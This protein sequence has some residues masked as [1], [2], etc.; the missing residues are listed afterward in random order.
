MVSARSRARSS[1]ARLVA[2]ARLSTRS[3]SASIPSHAHTRTTS[4]TVPAKAA[5]MAMTA[6]RLEVL[7]YFSRDQLNP[8]LSQ[9][10]LRPEPP[11]PVNLR[12][13]RAIR[14]DGRAFFR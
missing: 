9:P 11:K 4:S 7:R 3:M 1:W 5:C 13:I 10:P 8:P 14:S 2:T 6:C 12:S